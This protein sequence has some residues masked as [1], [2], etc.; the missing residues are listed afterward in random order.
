MDR[1]KNVFLLLILYFV[2]GLHI[3]ANENEKKLEVAFY[4]AGF[5]FNDGVGLDKDVVL[6]LEKRLGIEFRHSV[7]PRAR[8]WHELKEGLL[9][10]SVSG[11]ETPER[12]EFAWF[13]PYVAQK[14]KAI[15][16]KENSLKYKELEDFINDKNA[17]VA[18]I[19][20]F[21]H[22]EF[23]E[24]M[25]KKIENNRINEVPD[26]ERLFILLKNKRVDLVVSLSSFYSYEFKKQ[27]IAHLVEIRDWDKDNVG[28]VYGGLVLSKK[29]FSEE[30]Y[31]KISDIFMEMKND[32]TLEKIASKYLTKD[33]V[34]E[35]MRF[36]E[37]K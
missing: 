9:A 14:N 10:I 6:E 3:F 26:V 17:K 37:W 8:I 13:V 34:E 29:Y 11:V 7:K 21:N 22:G 25:F 32:G 36:L 27:N 20:G 1:F 35:S 33:E 19:R 30:E 2:L 12:R 5:L 28:V 23:Y 15:M 18:L 31:Q 16:L 4:E 24:E